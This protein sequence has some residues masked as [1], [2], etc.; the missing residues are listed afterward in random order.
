L[1]KLPESLRKS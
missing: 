1:S